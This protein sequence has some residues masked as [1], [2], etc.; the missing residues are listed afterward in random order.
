LLAS[1]ASTGRSLVRIAS[2]ASGWNASCRVGYLPPTGSRCPFY[3]T[4]E[5]RLTWPQSRFWGVNHLQSGFNCRRMTRRPWG[6]NWSQLRSL[7]ESNLR[8]QP[9][10]QKNFRLEGRIETLGEGLFHK[11]YLF[12]AGDQDLVLRLAKVEPG[13]QSR[14][15]AVSAV[16]RESKT[17]QTLQS[18]E[19]PFAVP[20]LICLVTDD[21]GETVGLI[22]SA[23]AGVPLK[24]L[25]HRF[26][27]ESQMKTIAQV[28]SAV[29]GLPKSKFSHLARHSDSR[30]HA[31]EKLNVLPGSL[32]EQF[33]E[34]ALARVWIMRNLPEGRTST[35]LHGDLLPQNLLLDFGDDPG[36]GSEI[37]VV[38]WESAQIGDAAYDLAVVT[39]GVR[40][41]FG[42][43]N[44]LQRLVSLYNEEAEQKISP[45]AVV[46]H[47]LVL[48]LRWLAESQK[49]SRTGGHG[50]E[51]YADL[52]SSILKRALALDANKSQT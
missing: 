32:F 48:H 41:P 34:A 14:K 13:L 44:G 37:A 25:L 47:E 2:T 11:N 21:S 7:I 18:L 1:R 51:H 33:A 4:P 40:R 50:P 52:L 39:R 19:F 26:E 23:V 12:E 45:A 16:R 46:V 8:Q 27:T 5:P 15:E 6:M 35:V 36:D 17:L 38:D 22:E 43:K 20:E 49:A 29:H 31:L 24:T 42:L 30:T 10:F 9:G 28:A 3:G